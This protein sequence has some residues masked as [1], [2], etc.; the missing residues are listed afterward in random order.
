MISTDKAGL[1]KQNSTSSFPNG[2][3]VNKESEQEK[4]IMIYWRWGFSVFL[5]SNL[6]T[7]K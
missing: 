4:S 2:D 6:Y 5:L 3:V 1:K 7:S